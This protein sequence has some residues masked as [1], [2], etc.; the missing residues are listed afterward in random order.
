MKNKLMLGLWRYVIEVPP[1][2]WEKGVQQGKRK[3]EREHGALSDEK[4]LIHH[5][6]VRELPRNSR[7]L[8]PELI[9]DGLG[10]PVDRIRAAL[11][12]LEQRM[13][14]LFR[15][16]DGDVVWAY[17][18]TVAETPHRIMFDTGERLYAA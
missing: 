11:D 2:L 3:F 6:A 9:S 13:T 17:P 1:F 18:V 7:P 10:I 12:Y 16:D 15:N 8:P 14:F 4:R 5:F